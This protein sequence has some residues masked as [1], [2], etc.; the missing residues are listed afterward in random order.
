MILPLAVIF[1][2]DWK[3]TDD[4]FPMVGTAFELGAGDEPVPLIT[5]V[6]DGDA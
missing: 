1:S 6:I 5:E 3:K 4:V 2:N